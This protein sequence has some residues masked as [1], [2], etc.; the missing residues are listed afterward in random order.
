MTHRILIGIMLL[1]CLGSGL[2][3]IYS[4][5]YSRTLLDEQS[6]LQRQQSELTLEWQ[7]LRLE[8]SAITAKAIVH[9]VARS[10]LRMVEPEPTD[11]IYI[12]P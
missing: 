5:Q 11:V 1:V 10:Q 7:Q 2:G 8:Q 6:H 12:K 4:E 9:E 3:L